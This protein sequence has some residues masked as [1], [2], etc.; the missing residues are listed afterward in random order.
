MAGT[1]AGGLK[2]RNTNYAKYGADH[3]SKIA[4]L[5]AESWI[6][7]GRKPRGFAWMKVNGQ[8]DKHKEASRKGGRISRRKAKR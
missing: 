2:A 1:V 3:Y 8:E 5:N 4:K 7:N 6:A